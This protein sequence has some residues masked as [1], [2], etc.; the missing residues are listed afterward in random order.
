MRWSASLDNRWSPHEYEQPRPSYYHAG[1]NFDGDQKRYVQ[2]IAAAHT[3]LAAAASRLVKLAMPPDLRAKAETPYKPHWYGPDDYPEEFDGIHAAIEWGY[4]KVSST[5]PIKCHRLALGHLKDMVERREVLI[6]GEEPPMLILYRWI[7]STK[8]KRRKVRPTS[9]HRRVPRLHSR[10]TDGSAAQPGLVSK[11]T[12]PMTDDRSDHDFIEGLI[13]CDVCGRWVPSY[14][15]CW[16]DPQG[17]EMLLP[18]GIP[19]MHEPGCNRCPPPDHLER[20]REWAEEYD[21]DRHERY[22]ATINALFERMLGVVT[23]GML[24]EIAEIGRHLLLVAF[25][26]ADDQDYR[27][28]FVTAYEDWG[29]LVDV[30]LTECNLYERCS[31]CGAVMPPHKGHDCQDL[32]EQP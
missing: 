32:D 21:R 13:E 25:S 24:Y 14:N 20:M 15:V 17:R 5:Q 12:A 3:Q 30:V 11:G 9:E 7:K 23:P 8:E 10:R 31:V 4:A 27:Q 1:P 6:P 26:H 2:Q 29:P 22:Q 28:F 16:N 19:S 18:M